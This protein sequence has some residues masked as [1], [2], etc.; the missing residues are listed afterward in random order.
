MSYHG[1]IRLGDTIDVKFTTRRFST[2]APHSLSGGTVAAYVG[3]GTTEITSGVTLTAD[4]DSRTGLNNVR[5]VASGGNGFAA[6]T[7]VQLVI[8]AGTVDSVSVVGE[9]VGEF[10]IE[11]RSAVM[12][13][14]AGRTLDVSAGGCA[15]IDWANVENQSETVNLE[16][17]AIASAQL[18]ASVS[19]TVGGVAAGGISGAS[20]SEDSGL[21]P[22]KTHPGTAQGGSSTTIVLAPNAASMDDFYNGAVVVVQTGEAG[23]GLGGDYQT[24]VITDY[25][26]STR[27][28]TV[29]PAWASNPVNGSPYSLRFNG[30]AGDAALRAALGLVAA[31][32]DTQL[33]DLPTNSE[34]ATALGTADDAVLAAI[35]ALNNPTTAQIATAVLTTA[36]TEAYRTTGG[37]ATLAQFCYEVIAHLGEFAN[38]GTT[39]TLKK[40][41]GSTTAKTFNYN[42][43]TNPTS[44]TE[45]T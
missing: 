15:G 29:S 14:T 34:L 25:A 27:V 31:N 7:N 33:G 17:T 12:P 9:V 11:N 6:A 40:L 21:R 41:D 3:N 38:S 39:K 23:T 30:Y 16:D 2:G 10:S 36:M 28:A 44:I 4:F 26:G 32:L 45:T 20:F 8:T 13:T 42:D 43:A 37:T 35:A 19:G 22:M 5:V 18:V 1:D 24:R